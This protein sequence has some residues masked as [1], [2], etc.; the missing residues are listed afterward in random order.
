MWLRAVRQASSAIDRRLVDEQHQ[1]RARVFAGRLGWCVDV[2][3]G[4]E[5][6]HYD[7]F[8]PTYIL[9]LTDQGTVAGGAR[10][11][12]ATG[13]NMLER[14]FPQ[15][16]AARRL[17]PHP[18]MVE[19]SRFCVNTAIEE[20]RGGGAI[21][22]ATLSLFA[23]IIEWSLANGY[24]EIVTATDL[25]FERILRRVGWPMRRLGEPRRIGNTTAI[26]GALPADLQSFERL[27][28]D[29]Y[30]SVIAPAQHRAA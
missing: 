10:L 19:S 5:K 25:R 27:R 13:P 11:L 30:R 23:G 12:P 4:R 14:T 17:D 1:L 18:G 21:H 16:L 2:H 3:D 8:D 9:A 29:S 22:E 20:G 7:A 24:S 6:D 28:P 15:L 26:A